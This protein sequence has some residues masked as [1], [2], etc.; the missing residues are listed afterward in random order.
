MHYGFG[1]LFWGLDGKVR[2]ITVGS[3]YDNP[4]ASRIGLRRL[5]EIYPEMKFEEGLFILPRLTKLK[6]RSKMK[7]D[8]IAI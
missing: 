6:M 7:I 4:D 1:D 5:K 8:I 2:S 3:V